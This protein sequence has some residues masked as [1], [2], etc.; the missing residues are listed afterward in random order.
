MVEKK[1]YWKETTIGAIVLLLASLGVNVI[2]TDDGYVPYACEKSTVP[3]MLCYK[4]SR[5]NDDG[6][7]SYCYFDRDNSKR[8]KKCS[9]GW[10]LLP[11]DNVDLECSPR[12]IAYTDNGKY[13]C[14]LDE[15]D[16]LN[17]VD[18]N[19]QSVNVGE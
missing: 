3:D 19:L 14:G 13:Y 11:P 6:I 12:I 18:E 5:V 8:F 16:N 4:L 7:Q 9:T 17:C 15:N 2:D 1:T 10:D